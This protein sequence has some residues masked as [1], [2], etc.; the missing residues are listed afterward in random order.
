V[1]KNEVFIPQ[2]LAG[3]SQAPRIIG[4]VRYPEN[5]SSQLLALKVTPHGVAATA[6]CAE[7]NIEDGTRFITST[8]LK[9]L[10]SESINMLYAVP[11]PNHSTHITA[12]IYVSVGTEVWIYESPTVS[13]TG[14]LLENVNLNRVSTTTSSMKMSAGPTV[15]NSGSILSNMYIGAGTKNQPVPGDE[16]FSFIFDPTKTYLMKVVP[17]ADN[18]ILSIGSAWCEE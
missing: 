7:A 1:A 13:A 12:E 4:G 16:S 18:A 17:G 6:T 5:S 14:S 10:P 9:S 2:D 3:T 8:I 15:S 11:S